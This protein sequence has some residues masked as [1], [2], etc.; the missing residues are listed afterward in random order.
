M[1]VSTDKNE[2]TKGQSWNDSFSTH[3]NDK[4][5]QKKVPEKQTYNEKM[6]SENPE[7]DA[8]DQKNIKDSS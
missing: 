1:G 5:I 6:L 2:P 4:K 8:A 3:M 7:Q